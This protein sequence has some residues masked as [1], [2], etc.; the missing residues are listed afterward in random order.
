VSSAGIGLNF[1]ASVCIGQILWTKNSDSNSAAAQNTVSNMFHY[2]F[3]KALCD[4]GIFANN[5]ADVIA[6]LCGTTCAGYTA[7]TLSFNVWLV[8]IYKDFVQMLLLLSSLLAV[9]ATLGTNKALY[10]LT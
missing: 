1:L 9:V 2:L 8:Y 6:F 3:V 10:F 4:L 7:G 5:L